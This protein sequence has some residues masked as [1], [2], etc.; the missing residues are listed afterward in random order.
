M[1]LL[2]TFIELGLL[3]RFESLRVCFTMEFVECPN[4]SLFWMKL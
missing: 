4:V 3:V 2:S 1:P